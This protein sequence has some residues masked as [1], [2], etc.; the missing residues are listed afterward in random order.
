MD[1]LAVDQRMD[2]A[3]EGNG[4]TVIRKFQA[5]LRQFVTT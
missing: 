1:Q 5:R 2:P 4:R 3:D